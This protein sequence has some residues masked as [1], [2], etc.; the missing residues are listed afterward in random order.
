MGHDGLMCGSDMA[1]N[2]GDSSLSLYVFSVRAGVKSQGRTSHLSNY[3]T[4]VEK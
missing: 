3:S 2:H 4:T 1:D